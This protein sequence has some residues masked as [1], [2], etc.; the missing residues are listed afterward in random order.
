MNRIHSHLKKKRPAGADKWSDEINELIWNFGGWL[1][2]EDEYS[3]IVISSRIRLARNLNKY[4]FPNKA[5]ELA[6]QEVVSKVKE[7]CSKCNI[8][9]NANYIEVNDLAEWDAKYFVERRLASP[10]FIEK[11]I[12]AMLVIG[13]SETLSIMI[14]EEDHVRIQCIEAGL[15]IDSAWTKI[16]SMDDQLEENLSFSYSKEFGYITACPT[17]LGTGMRV[18]IFVHLPALSM[19][20]KTNDVFKS[21]PTSEIAIRGFYGEG[22]DSIGDIYQISNQLTLG[23]AEN[24][25]IERMY[26]TSKKIIALERKARN[27]ILTERKVKLEDSVCRALAVLQSAKIITSL[28]AMKLLSTL[29]FGREMGLVNNLSRLAI[30]Q[31]MVLVQPAHLQ[32]IYA[33]QMDA[34]GRDI[35]R[36]EF[37]RENLQV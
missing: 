1:T 3:D 37:I 22:T 14:N 24:N 20:D 7:A 26:S 19:L 25:V 35:I 4:S 2:N 18:S 12:P 36:A 32:K 9:K 23:R 10:Q 5:S 11:E 13:Q 31:L 21:L 27:R 30:N 16:S 28:E 17:N 15:E 34:E 29:R 33:E 8:L 6:L